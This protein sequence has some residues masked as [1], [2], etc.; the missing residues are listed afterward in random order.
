MGSARDHDLVLFGATG[1]V[2]TL[3]AGYLARAAAPGTRIALAGRSRERLEQVRD[4][5]P[6]PAGDWPLLV[7]DSADRG[8]LQALA[9]TKGTSP[10]RSA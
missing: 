7:A 6:A 2:G 5:L 4:A 8:C 3:T 1:F 9:R 10:V